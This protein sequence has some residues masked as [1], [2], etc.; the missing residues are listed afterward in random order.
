MDGHCRRTTSIVRPE[1]LDVERRLGNPKRAK[2]VLEEALLADAYLTQARYYLALA[3]LDLKQ[4][5][6]AIAHLDLVVKSGEKRADV[7]LSLGT[8]HL[9]SGRVDKGLGVLIEATHLDPARRDVRIQLARAY[10]LQGL[11]DDAESQLALGV[12]PAVSSAASPFLQQRDLEFNLYLEQG[13]LRLEQ[14]R[15]DPARDAFRKVLEMDPDHGPAN[16][17]L[18]TVYL[19]QAEYALAFEYANR[20]EKLGFPLPP[21]ERKR[22]DEGRAKR[23]KR[24]GTRE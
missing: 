10:R 15:L 7:Y 16:R 24:I 8:A 12:P 18:A 11:L 5:D 22:L 3:L 14:G 13:L 9:D 19:R 1:C 17:H 20:A 4:P 6:E 2:E 21:A 23:P